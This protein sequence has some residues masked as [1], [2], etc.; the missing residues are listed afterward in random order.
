MKKFLMLSSALTLILHAS[1]VTQKPQVLD[2]AM[3]QL[4]NG[5][6]TIEVKESM[7]YK[8][9]FENHRFVIAKDHLYYAPSSENS[10]EKAMLDGVVDGS[11]NYHGN[12]KGYY[13]MRFDVKLKDDKLLLQIGHNQKKYFTC[14]EVEVTPNDMKVFNEQPL[15]QE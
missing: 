15:N 11:K 7:R 12:S 6:R 5:K 3:T 1:A 8:G 10:Y 14:K 4:V 13:G 2:C 9:N